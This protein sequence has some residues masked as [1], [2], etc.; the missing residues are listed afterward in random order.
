MRKTQIVALA[1]G[2]VLIGGPAL[3]G[4][5]VMEKTTTTTYSG[6]VTE[7]NPS[8]STVVLRSTT[9]AAPTDVFVHREDDPRRLRGERRDV[10]RDQERAGHRALHR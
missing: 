5:E 4:T 1:L 2:A 9:S 10:G 8:A 6:T 7:V 3:A